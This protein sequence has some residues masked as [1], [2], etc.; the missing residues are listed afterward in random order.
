MTE[1][2]LAEV[3]S[4]KAQIAARHL[5]ASGVGVSKS[6]LYFQDRGRP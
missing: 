1:V 4:P 6:L 2:M 5:I 3:S